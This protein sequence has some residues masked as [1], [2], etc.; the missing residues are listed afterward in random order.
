MMKKLTFVSNVVTQPFNKLAKT[1]PDVNI[2]HYDINQVHQFFAMDVA[3]DYVVLLLTSKYFF[4]SQ[5]GSESIQTARELVSV[6]SKYKAG[7]NA[8]IILS[9]ITDTQPSYFFTPG[10]KI[11]HEKNLLEINSVFVEAANNIA[12]LYILDIDSIHKSLGESY[13]R[14]RNDYIFQSP[15]SKEAIDLITQEIFTCINCI[16]VARKKVC[17]LDADNTLWNGI[18][19]EDGIDGVQVDENHPGILYKIFQQQ[20]LRLKETGVLLCLVTKNNLSDIEEFFTAKKMPLSLSDFIAI[21]SNWQPK[22]QNII[23]LGSELN[24]GLDSFVF[25]DDNPFEIN[26][27]ISA[28]P[29][30]QT[31]LIDTKNI[32]SIV[33]IFNEHRFFF[34]YKTTNEDLNKSKMY[35]D[36]LLR[37]KHKSDVY[38]LDE[39]IKSLDIKVICSINNEKNVSRVSQL[40]NKTNQFNLT[41]RRYTESDISTFH[42]NG[43]VFDFRVSDIYGDMGIVGVV[44]VVDNRIDTF[45]LSCR[46]LGRKIE[47]KILWAVCKHCNPPLKAEYIQTQKNQQVES[48]Y[49]RMGYSTID[50]QQQAK[51]YSITST[52][53]D[54][55]YI[56]LEYK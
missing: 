20:L 48:F 45:L 7:S 19:G 10:E 33:R 6:I 51:T 13:Y 31:I 39:Y 1:L 17:V 44:I 50:T 16:S 24:L 56:S 28:A 27:V 52:P 5:C 37:S 54:I 49:D 11:L 34:S 46:V 42:K 4:L 53:D 41:T 9:N 3:T 40:T 25:I 36:E 8:K 47:E 26:E 43:I 38:S 2:E 12:D 30:V 14:I 18:L 21:K 55:E 29:A 22:S 15:F 35:K 23:E 32:E